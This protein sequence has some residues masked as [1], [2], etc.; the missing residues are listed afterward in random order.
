MNRKTIPELLHALQD[1]GVDLVAEPP[2]RLLFDGPVEELEAG[3]LAEL[4]ARSAEVVSYLN[5]GP[6]RAQGPPAGGGGEGDPFRQALEE[7]EGEFPDAWMPKPGEMLVGTLVRYERAATSYGPCSIAVVMDEQSGQL[8][9]VWL[10]HHV[11]RGEFAALRPVPGERIGL[12]RLPD[13]ENAHGQ[14]YRRWLLRVDR[15]GE[16][17]AVPDFEEGAAPKSSAPVHQEAPRPTPPSSA[18]Y[19]ADDGLPF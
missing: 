4:R 1:A 17:Q 9:A 6:R 5:G 14:R 10:L 12:K 11:L 7:D 3:V 15:R 18:S 2:A 19:P 13:A 16:D 8:W